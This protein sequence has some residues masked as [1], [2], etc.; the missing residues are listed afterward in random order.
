MNIN[1][2][3]VIILL[4]KINTRSQFTLVTHEVRVLTPMCT[5]HCLEKMVTAGRSSSI[6]RKTISSGD[7][8]YLKELYINY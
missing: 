7:S 8:E 3:N 5:S 4:Q 6:A 1:E 2:E